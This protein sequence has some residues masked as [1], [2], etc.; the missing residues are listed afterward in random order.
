MLLTELARVLCGTGDKAR[1]LIVEDDRDLARVISEVF[2]R[3]SITVQTSRTHSRRRSK[4]ALRS[5]LI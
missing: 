2:T 4:P 5:S 1:I 3:D